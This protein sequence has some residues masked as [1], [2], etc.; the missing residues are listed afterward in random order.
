VGRLLG[1]LLVDHPRGRFLFEKIGGKRLDV[2]RRAHGFI[3][4]TEDEAIEVG[5]L[6]AGED[7]FFVGE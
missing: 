1:S 3:L 7:D 2:L 6:V 4:L 5:V